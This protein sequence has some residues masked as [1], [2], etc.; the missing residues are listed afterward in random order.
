M[1]EANWIGAGTAPWIAHPTF[2]EV[3][4]AWLLPPG[5]STRVACALARIP[6]GASVPE[7]AHAEQ[8]DILYVLRGGARMWIEGRGEPTLRQ[9]DFLRVPAGLRHCPFDFADDFL[10]F[11]LWA[12]ASRR[13]D[14]Q[15]SR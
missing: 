8:D 10:A 14:E 6:D 9:G 7:H 15:R 11:N 3:R 4:L 12:D 13:P 5:V 2:A 1:N